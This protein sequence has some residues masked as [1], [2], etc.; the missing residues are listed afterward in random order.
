MRL[1]RADC[2]YSNSAKQVS[3]K[4]SKAVLNLKIFCYYHCI[5]YVLSAKSS[6]Q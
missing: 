2:V 5:S 4:N 6:A 1:L 3:C